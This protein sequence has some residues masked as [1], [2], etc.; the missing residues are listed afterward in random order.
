M[1][2]SLIQIKMRNLKISLFGC[3][4]SRHILVWSDEISSLF[5]LMLDMKSN[6]LILFPNGTG[7]KCENH[8][9]QAIIIDT[10]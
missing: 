8:L 1:Q 3:Q 10:G 5:L 9:F 2:N 6:Y 4:M 7:E